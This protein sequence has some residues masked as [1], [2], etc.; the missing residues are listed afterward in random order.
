MKST[1]DY[2]NK[3]AARWAANGYSADC[4]IPCPGAFRAILDKG[5]RV[6]GL[7]CGCGYDCKRLR[8]RGFSPVGLDFSEENLHIAMEQNPRIELLC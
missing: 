7:G 8:E 4:E 3:T 6:L 1:M 2:Y 5:L